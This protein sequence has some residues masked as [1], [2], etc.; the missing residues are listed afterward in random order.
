LLWKSSEAIGGQGGRNI[1]KFKVDGTSIELE[2]APGKWK[3]IDTD[4]GDRRALLDWFATTRDREVSQHIFGTKNRNPEKINFLEQA[5]AWD[6]LEFVKDSLAA[7]FRGNV[8]NS[9]DSTPLAFA[10]SPAMAKLLLDN[11]ADPNFQ[12]RKLTWQETK[13]PASVVGYLK[14]V[15]KAPKEVLDL[16]EEAAKKKAAAR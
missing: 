1:T 11:G 15:A 9:E 14:H 10:R 5:V 12:V 16:V 4:E 6:D 2:E 7:G 3:K 13:A 8:L